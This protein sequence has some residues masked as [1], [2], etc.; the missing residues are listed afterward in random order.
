MPSLGMHMVYASNIIV[1]WISYRLVF[2]LLPLVTFTWCKSSWWHMFLSNFFTE[3]GNLLIPTVCVAQ[4]NVCVIGWNALYWEMGQTLSFQ[5]FLNILTTFLSVG[6]K[7]ALRQ[8][9]GDFGY[10]SAMEQSVGCVWPLSWLWDE[11]HWHVEYVGWTARQV[12]QQQQQEEEE[13][14]EQ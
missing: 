11:S 8:L 10:W 6:P 4:K 7:L 5:A 13:H 9:K 3:F 2:A 14:E 12:P 1:D